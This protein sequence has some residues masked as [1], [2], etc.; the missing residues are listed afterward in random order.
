ME[1]CVTLCHAFFRDPHGRAL[2]A[3]A[4]ACTAAK[5]VAAPHWYE[6]ATGILAIPAAVIGCAYS[7]LL[8]K[9]TQLESRKLELEI[10]KEMVSTSTSF[11]L[12]LT[13]KRLSASASGDGGNR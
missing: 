9:K 11:P 3:G 1:R 5:P 8:I 10:K 7:Y 13:T 12:P 2:F 6:Q 4:I